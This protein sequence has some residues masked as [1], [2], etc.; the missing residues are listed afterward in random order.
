MQQSHFCEEAAHLFLFAKCSNILRYNS[1]ETVVYNQCA[2]EM[3]RYTIKSQQSHQVE[4]PKQKFDD[5]TP[6]PSPPEPGEVDV[7][8]AGFPWSAALCLPGQFCLT[9]V[10]VKAILH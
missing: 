1:P 10:I 7:I 3:L 4:V 6:V 9:S 8:T 2:N 5:K